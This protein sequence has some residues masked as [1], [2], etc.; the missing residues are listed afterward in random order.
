[1]GQTPGFGFLTNNRIHELNQIRIDTYNTL[2]F[3]KSYKTMSIHR[4]NS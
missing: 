2:F 1:M 4:L 3:G